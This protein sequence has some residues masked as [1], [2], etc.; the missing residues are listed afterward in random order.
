M[1][2][3]KQMMTIKTQIAMTATTIIVTIWTFTMLVISL[4]CFNLL[5]AQ[6]FDLGIF[7]QG[8]WLL[9]NNQ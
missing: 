2:R 1:M 8:V 3:L 7:Q 9:A 6:A 5:G 4:W